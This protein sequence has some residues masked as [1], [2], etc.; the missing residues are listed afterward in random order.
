VN[1][2]F[3]TRLYSRQ[4]V[5]SIHRREES[6]GTAAGTLALALAAW[7]LWVIVGWVLM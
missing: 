5:A 7:V 1:E 6:V 4:F 3:D 2:I